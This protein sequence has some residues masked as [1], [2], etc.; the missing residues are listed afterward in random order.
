MC[1]ICG[2]Y[3]Y[4]RSEAVE[5]AILGDMLQ[6]IRHRGPDDEGTYFDGNL[7]FGMRR[8]SIIDLSGGQQPMYNEDGSIVVVYNGEIYNFQALADDLKRRGHVFKSVCDT[9]VLVHLYEEYGVDCVT[10]LRGMFGFAIWD[11]HYRRLLIARDHLGVKPMYYTQRDHRL[12]FG[13]EIKALLQHPDVHAALNL[14]GLSEFLSLRYVPAPQTMFEGIFALPPGHLLLCDENGIT[15]QPY[16]DVVYNTD[17]P[18]HTEAEY[19]E[20][21]ESLLD[22][23]VK[24][25]LMSDVPFGAFLSGGIDSS[26]IVALMS[27]HLNTPVKT[28]SV[29]FKGE[30]EELS[31]LPYARMVAEQYQTDHHE[32]LLEAHD[33]IDLSEKIVWHLDQPIGDQATMANYMV[34]R[35]AS[36]H[37]KMVLTGEGGDELFGGYAR[38]AGE[39]FSPLFKNIP[40]PLRSLAL[41]TAGR[42]PGLRKAKIGLYALCQPGEAAR[43]S[44]WFPLFNRTQKQALLSDELIRTIDADCSEEVFAQQLQ[45]TNAKDPLS[46]M[47]YVDTKLWLPDDLL[48]RGDKTSMATSLEARVPLLDYKLVEF[49]ATVPSHLKVKGMARK[50]LL[51]QVSAKMLPKEIIHRKKQGFPIPISQW[52]RKEANSFLRDHLCSATFKQRGL[53]NQSY[54]D[55]LLHEHETQFADHGL[56]LWGL[57]NVELWHRLYIDHAAKVAP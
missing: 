38:Y 2:V 52:F 15:V 32:V 8:L 3:Q 44:N 54:V 14:E 23:S 9:E 43:L 56:L 49:A 22:E 36:Q 27:R 42:I 34:A 12:V 46:R 45:R 1:G 16:W 35:L 26:T 18:Q 21:L 37:V 50:Y 41:D 28:F 17:Q 11:S 48:A 10:H 5:R 30:G 40:S 24:M 13:S 31:E 4:D 47:L 19:T 7:A 29:G 33:L 51:K 6:A 55:R 25:Q 53:F 39:R 20:R 57:L